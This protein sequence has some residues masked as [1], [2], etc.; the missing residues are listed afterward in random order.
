MFTDLLGLTLQNIL[1]FIFAG[2][3]SHILQLFHIPPMAHCQKT[4]CRLAFDLC[5]WYTFS[6]LLSY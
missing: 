2:C 1:I 4:N 5:K 3:L 6:Y